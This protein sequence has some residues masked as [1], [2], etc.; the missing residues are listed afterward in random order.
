MK[1]PYIGVTGFMSQEEV[2]WATGAIPPNAKRK[3]MVGILMSSKTIRGVQNKWPRR[4]PLPKD[5]GNIFFAPTPWELNLVHFATDDVSNLY[6]DLDKAIE[7]AGPWCRGFQLNLAWPNP[8]DLELFL[9]HRK[10]PL[11]AV[12]QIGSRA[13][14]E[15]GRDP[16]EVAKK[17]AD[18]R[19]SADHILLDGSGGKGIPLN[20]HDTRAYLSEIR[21]REPS[22]GLGIAGGLD[23][24]NLSPIAKLLEK[25]PDLSWDAE[26]KL[27]N[28]AGDMDRPNAIDY[29]EASF[30]LSEK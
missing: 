29:I 3:L 22:F 11:F 27:R 13:L 9:S 18:Y 26:G 25:F 21:N 28:Y 2:L 15:A 8:K 19:E 7:L 24:D 4:Y 16:K 23:K 1:L 6:I 5:A 17:L 10:S 20:F 12:L 14:Q 30:K